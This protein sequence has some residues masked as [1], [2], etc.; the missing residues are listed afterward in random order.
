[1]K[2]ELNTNNSKKLIIGVSI[3]FCAIVLVVGTSLAFFT[4]SDSKEIGNVVT[5]NINGTLKFYDNNDY[6]L[7]ILFPLMK[8]M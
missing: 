1:M 6:S 8:K 4:Q 5:E 2:K 3:L 7:V